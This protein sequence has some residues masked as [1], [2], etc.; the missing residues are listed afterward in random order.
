MQIAIPGW[1][2]R[3][4]FDAYARLPDGE[5]KHKRAIDSYIDL[6]ERRG[7]SLPSVKNIGQG[8][9]D[10]LHRLSSDSKVFSKDGWDKKRPDLFYQLE[11][12]RWGVRPVILAQAHEL[13]FDETSVFGGLPPVQSGVVVELPLFEDLP[14][15]D[16]QELYLLEMS[17]LSGLINIAPGQRIVKIG[18]GKPNDRRNSL[19]TGNP[20]L[21][22]PRLTVQTRNVRAL[23]NRLHKECSGIRLNGEWFS[24]A[25]PDMERIGGV[26][27]R[28]G[29]GLLDD[30]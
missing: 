6:A 29:M 1:R 2:G 16:V 14:E 30:A 28:H 5:G 27:I 13:H 18:I 24:I 12:G 20:C 7:H 22:V 21:I 25:A 4:V 23:E 8:I 17:P 9:K 11:P 3:L 10:E 26:I 19:Q 15:L